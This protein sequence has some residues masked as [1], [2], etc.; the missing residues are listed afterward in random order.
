MNSRPVDDIRVVVFDVNETLSDLSPMSQRFAEIGAPG[1]AA[2]IWF[3]S[4]LRDGFALTA[5][6]S[7]ASFRAIGEGALRAVLASTDIDRDIDDAVQHVME[8]F[9]SLDV[10]PDVTDGVRRLKS[11]GLR[12]VTLTNGSTDV[13]ER[14]LTKAGVRAE[15]EQLISVDSAGVWKPAPGSYRHA[16]EVCGVA[17]EQMLLVAGHPWDIDGAGRA[18]MH[19]A[20]INRPGGP[21]PSYFSAPELTV[22]ALTQLADQIRRSG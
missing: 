4:L 1:L 2:K 18:G 12:L 19:T 13:A 14:L 17:L 21:Y 15:F 3:A 6:G 10:H 20:W 22:S 11:V 9:A 7:F 5:S 16:A 8:G